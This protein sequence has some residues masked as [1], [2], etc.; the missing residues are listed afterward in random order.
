MAHLFATQTINPSKALS[1]PMDVT[2]CTYAHIYKPY[3]RVNYIQ[4]NWRIEYINSN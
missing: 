4:R 1:F 2:L 3:R